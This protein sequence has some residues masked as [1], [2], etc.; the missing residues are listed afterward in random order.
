MK[1]LLL[2]LCLFITSHMAHSQILIS[3]LLGDKLNSPNLEFGLEGGFNYTKI[4]G[5]ESNDNLR[6]FNLGF[7]F[8][9]RMKNQLFLY[10]GVQVKSSFGLDDLQEEDLAFLDAEML[11]VEGNYSQKVSAFMVP[12]LAKYKFKNHFYVEAGPQV[13]LIYNS[14]VEFTSD[15]NNRDVKIKDY[16]DNLLNWFNGGLAFGTGYKLMQGQG[17]T[18]GVR[19]YQ[20]LTDVFKNK[21]GSIHNSFNIKVNIPIGAASPKSTQEN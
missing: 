16:N 12:I 9:V 11:S 10:S 14:W 2:V 20:G 13:G 4:S 7:Y 15:V 5:F 3:L 1:K 8:D 18:I 19:Y 21:S 6:N 17:W